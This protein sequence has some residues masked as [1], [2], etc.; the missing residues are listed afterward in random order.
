MFS[1]LSRPILGLYTDN[2]SAPL[3]ARAGLRQVYKFGL[4]SHCA[5]VNQ[6]V[7]S[8]TSTAAA[9]QFRP[10]TAITNDMLS[11][12]STY[13]DAIIR[14]TAF[15]NSSSLGRSSHTAYYLLLFGSILSAV[16]LVTSVR[17]RPPIFGLG[18]LA[19]PRPS[20][21]IHSTWTLFVSA[22]TAIV[23]GASVLAG[24]A[25]WSVLIKRAKDV[26][27]WTVQPGQ[28]PLGIEV[29]TG[30]GLHCAWVAFGLLTISIIFHTF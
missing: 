11:N 5:Y 15:A 19:F 9:Y 17:F 18:S 1:A 12:Y 16:S 8:C 7:G 30:I 20:G 24:S 21:M 14:D 13:T 6:S 27:S 26:N 10:Y 25:I 22:S 2:A 4:Y 29:T 3:N 23:A 28:F